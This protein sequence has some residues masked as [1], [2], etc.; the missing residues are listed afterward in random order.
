MY[1]KQ[2]KIYECSEAKLRENPLYKL[3][4]NQYFIP[5]IYDFCFVRSYKI[6]SKFLWREIDLRIIDFVV[7]FIARVF[8]KG[9]E[10]ARIIQSG[11]LTHSLIF[12]IC[13]IFAMLAVLLVVF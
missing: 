6:I 8:V 7:D 11:V 5:K 4:I 2:S 3:L 9:G 12:M 13:G 10:R 1:R